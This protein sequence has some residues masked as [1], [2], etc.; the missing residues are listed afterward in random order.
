LISV[1]AGFVCFGLMFAAK[2]VGYVVDDV[3]ERSGWLITD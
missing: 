2:L 1:C 3:G